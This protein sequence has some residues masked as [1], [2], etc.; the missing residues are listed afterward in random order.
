MG[1]WSWKPHVPAAEKRAKA[2]RAVKKAQKDGKAMSPVV[3][4]GRGAIAKTFW[5]KAWCDN[6]EAY[7][8][9]ANR[10]PRGRS[11]VRNGSVIDLKIE[12]G[13][14]LA[15]V[16][17]SS[18]YKVEI[19]I[20]AM[21]KKQ[22]GALIK[23][24]TGSIASLVELLQGKFSQAV[25]A[26][27]C[28]PKTG[29][30]PS[31]KEIRLGCSCPDWASMCKHVAAVLYG[32]G[33][34]LDEQPELLFVLRQ[35]DAADLVAQA[36]ELP[37]KTKKTPAKAKLLDAAALADVFGIEMATA[38][39]AAKRAPGR[40][41]AAPAAKRPKTGAKAQPTTTGAKNAAAGKTTPVSRTISKTA[42]T[43]ASKVSKTRGGKES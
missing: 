34:R 30:F 3:L 43:A 5:G 29:L 6:L 13:R 38:D 17:G 4:A 1:D 26:R 21:P 27:L 15:L 8:D 31:P 9:Y 14:V 40:K 33:A 41:R 36:A 10:L 16:M 42:R 25:M 19:G 11:Y 28:V 12:P 39:T 37:A 24:C 32:V 7:S 23:D 22:W 2:E 35:V 20:A 18:L